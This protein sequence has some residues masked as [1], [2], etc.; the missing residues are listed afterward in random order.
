MERVTRL[1]SRAGYYYNF[2][3]LIYLIEVNITTINTTQHNTTL[4]HRLNQPSR[5]SLHMLQVAAAAS[6]PIVVER[7]AGTLGR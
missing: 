6:T 3:T 7:D 4:N 2:L 5:P 1:C